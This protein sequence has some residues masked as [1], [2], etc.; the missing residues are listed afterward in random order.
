MMSFMDRK[1]LK[2]DSSP[3]FNIYD[4]SGWPCV[5]VGQEEAK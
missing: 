5:N 3:V 2:L 1:T 4:L